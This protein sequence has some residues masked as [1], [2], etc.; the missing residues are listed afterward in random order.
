MHISPSFITVLH[1]FSLSTGLKAAIVQVLR[2]FL[3]ASRY[4]TFGQI[5]S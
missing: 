3:Q 5:R 4:V 2:L 1:V